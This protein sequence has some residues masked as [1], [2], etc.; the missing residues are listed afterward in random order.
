VEK[1]KRDK[2]Y[3]VRQNINEKEIIFRF[4][5]FLHL[6]LDKDGDQRGRGVFLRHPIKRVD[7]EQRHGGC[8]WIMC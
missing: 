5:E 2:T 4:Y 3:I 7:H 1:H 8:M 6:F